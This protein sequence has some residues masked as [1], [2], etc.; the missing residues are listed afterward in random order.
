MKLHRACRSLRGGRRIL[1]GTAAV[2]LPV[3]A[4]AVGSP[5]DKIFETNITN[6]MSVSSGEPQIA[7]DPTNPRNL[8][9]VEFGM[10]STRRPAYAFNPM[11]L[12]DLLQ[13]LEGAMANTGRVMLS[14]DGGDHWTQSGPPPAYDPNVSPRTGG[15]DPFIAYG[16]EGTLYVG[17]EAG[18]APKLG[19]AKT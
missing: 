17:D 19:A 18:P 5:P 12:A 3:W 11:M 13:D 7:L 16:P 15:G 2:L 9:I 6:D 10:G 8:A 14:K 4:V 1:A